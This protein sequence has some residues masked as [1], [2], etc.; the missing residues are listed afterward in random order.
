MKPNLATLSFTAFA[1]KLDLFEYGPTK[2]TIFFTPKAYY[3]WEQI[4][5]HLNQQFQQLGVENVYF[6]SL[7]PLPLLAKEQQHIQGF[8][9]ELFIINRIGGKIIKES[10][11][12]RPTSEVLFCAYFEKKVNSYRD[13]PLLLNQ[14]VNIWRWEQN[15]NPFLR[16]TEFLW[17]EGHTIHSDQESAWTFCQKIRQVYQTF[18]QKHLLLPVFSGQKSELEKFA[19][20]ETTWT[21]ETI[22]PD[23]QFLQVATVHYLGQNFTKPFKIRFLDRNN[24]HQI[25]HQTSWGVSTRSIAAIVQI[26]RDEQGI[27]LPSFLAKKLVAIVPIYEKKTT[28]S[29]P[30]I[31]QYCQLIQ[32]KLEQL[33]VKVVQADSQSKNLSL[34]FQEIEL[35]GVPIRLEIGHR[36]VKQ[37]QVSFVLRSN[38]KKQQV[39]LNHFLDNFTHL[40]EKLKQETF[41]RATRQ[42]N[43]KPQKITTFSQ[44]RELKKNQ[45][46]EMFFCNQITCEKTIK[47]ATQT[48]SRLVWKETESDQK[49]VGKCFKCQK[50]TNWKAL[51]GRSY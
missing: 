34:L 19:G 21:L 36:E 46:F 30:A 43:R 17:Q 41:T 39:S 50:E 51:F 20:A 8:A 10:L 26:H 42:T 49:T 18:F 27:I 33:H 11:A 37:Q 48:V 47:Q 3:F 4:Q 15:P 31:A 38:L 1:Q 14:W 29:K 13:L 23:G 2:G 45:V 35:E 12:L 16:N 7:I 25:P 28:N 9:P 44:Y 40:L 22:L 32:E 5:Q 24:Q 6:P